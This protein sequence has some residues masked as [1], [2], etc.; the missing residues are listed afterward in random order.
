MTNSFFRGKRPWSNIKDQVL[1]SYMPP[2]LSKVAKLNK[3]IL[4]VDAFAGPGKFEDSSPGSPLIICQA[5]EK[6]ARDQYLAIFVNREK[7]DHEKLSS[8]LRA[9]IDQE[10]V[11]SIYGPA[12]SLLAEVHQILT[13][14]TVFLY[15]DPF[16]LKGCEFSLL[17]PFIMRDK[18]HSTEIVINLSVPTIHRLAACKAVA[19][20]RKDL[21]QIRG[22]N[23]RL[24][25]VLGGDYW[26]E[27]MWN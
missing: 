13:D 1:G 11:I 27:I 12:E 22:F 25:Q 16:G 18:V 6:H 17:E 24:T 19:A 10:K 8:V 26:Q 20:G 15:I 7:E 14:Q 21:K 9:F 23:R 5:A 3:P 4:I 2:Y